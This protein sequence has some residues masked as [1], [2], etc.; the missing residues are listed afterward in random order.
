MSRHIRSHTNGNTSC[1]VTKKKWKFSRKNWRFNCRIIKV[2]NH[3]YS[4][5][6]NVGSHFLGDFWH[7]GF[8]ITVSRWRITCN[9]TKVSLRSYSRIAL[10]KILS[11][12][13]QCIVNG[14]IAVRMVMSQ[15]FTNDC[16]TF[17]CFSTARKIKLVHCV[18][19][20]PV[21]RL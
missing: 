7:F 17:F 16:G 8:G 3:I 12:T 20:S 18:H 14:S 4:F 9:R 10:C 6:V 2:R 1:S 19:N 13:N 21:N 15:N 5:F 11:Q